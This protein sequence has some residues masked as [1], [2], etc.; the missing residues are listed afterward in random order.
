MR[1]WV[2]GLAVVVVVLAA[3]VHWTRLDSLVAWYAV[4]SALLPETALEEAIGLKAYRVDIE[5][6]PL[7]GIDDDV[8]ALTHNPGR[9]TLFTVLNS[10]PVIVELTLE[11]KILRQLQVMGA[12]VLEGLTYVAGNRYVIAEE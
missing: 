10:K 11:G 3:V 8:S 6:R 4:K 12:Q 2:L 1:K 7:M 5:G 9:N